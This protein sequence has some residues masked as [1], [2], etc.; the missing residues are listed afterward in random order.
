MATVKFSP[1]EVRYK[2]ENDKPTIELY[3]K[4]DG[5]KRICVQVKD[6]QPYFWVTGDGPVEDE[7]ITRVE[8]TKKKLLGKEVIAKKVFVKQPSDVPFVRDKFE[9]LEADIP[10]TRRYLIDR[11]VTPLL[12]YKADGDYAE[13][14]YQVDLFLAN[15]ITYESDETPEIKILAVDI[16]THTKIGGETSPEKDPI[17]MI[18]LYGEKFCKVLTCKKFDTSL[19]YVEHLDDEVQMLERFK[20]IVRNFKPDV[21]TGYFSDGFDLPYLKARSEKYKLS[22]NLGLDN[23]GIRKRKGNLPLSEITGIAH[24]DAFRFVK[25]MFRTSFTSFKLNQV[26]KELLGEGKTDVDLKELYVAWQEPGSD[27]EKFL[28]YN[29]QDAKLAYR[30]CLKLMP[31]LIELTKMIGLTPSDV[32]RMSFSQLVEWYLLRLAP[33][34]N[35]FAPNRPSFKEERKRRSSSYEGAFVFEPTPGIY[36]NVAVFDFM[37]LYPTIISSHNI[38][39]D[40]LISH[41]GSK[42]GVLKGIS[43]DPKKKGFISTVIEEVI[44]KRIKVKSLS[45]ANPEDPVLDARQQALKTV[46]NSIYGYYG[47]FGARWYSLECAEA[48]TAYG[49]HHVRDVITKAQNAG[50]NVLYSDTDSVFMALE[51]RDLKEVLSFVDKINSK[52]PGI[53]G[54]EYEGLYKSG[55]FVAAK[56]TESGAK[57]KYALLSHDGKMKVKGFETVRRNLSKVAK[58]TQEKVLKMLLL[59]K[60]SEEIADYVKKVVRDIREKQIEID[61]VII[62]TQISKEISNY[63]NVPPHVAVAKKLEKRG[64]KVKAGT[65][66]GYVVTGRKGAIRDRVSLPDELKGKEYDAEYYVTNQVLPAVEKLLE[67]IGYDSTQLAQTHEQKKLESFFS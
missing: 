31:N 11:K 53:M 60:D 13:S 14:D 56:G 16:E 23:T 41:E 40:T 24:I 47:F 17:I 22:L 58:E 61:K 33:D 59:E 19:D 34:F 15:K 48:I 7:K 55:V 5:G 29:L 45:K 65:T 2:S 51:N 28:K 21:I 44:Q 3:G 64:Q 42:D 52:L 26:A 27:L 63:A 43:F 4:T 12:N 50:M 66:V 10:F 62:T 32:S 9:T 25:R 49:R 39:P 18:A 8:K 38:S 46:A 37:S 67:V 57:K 54:L 6:F 30:L 1:V 20:Q 36:K 35:E